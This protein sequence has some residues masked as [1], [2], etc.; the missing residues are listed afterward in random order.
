MRFLQG[1]L[2]LAIVVVVVAFALQNNEL[3]SVELFAWAA[4]APISV[5]VAV[6]YALG[7]LT[8]WTV[9]AFARRSLR[10]VVAGSK[11]DA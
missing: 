6:A 4:K 7:M 3:L 11:V 9:L 2:L 1:V 10:D 8:G 5:V